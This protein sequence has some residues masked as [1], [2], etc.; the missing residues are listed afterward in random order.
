MLFTYIYSNIE[1]LGN[2]YRGGGGLDEPGGR[3]CEYTQKIAGAFAARIL[4]V[5]RQI[6]SYDKMDPT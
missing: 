1:N 2:I 3:A 4:E 6:Y 5:W